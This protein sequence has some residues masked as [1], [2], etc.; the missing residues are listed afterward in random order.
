MLQAFFNIKILRVGI[1]PSGAANNGWDIVDLL[2][3]S[4]GVFHAKGCLGIT[5]FVQLYDGNRHIR[6]SR[7]PLGPKSPKSLE[8]VFPGLPA[9]RVE[10]VSKKSQ[11]TRKRV[12]KMSKSVFGD[13]FDTF[14]TLWAGGIWG[15]EGL[16]TP[17]YGSS[18][19]K[20]SCSSGAVQNY[21]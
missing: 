17:V 3:G 7:D 19:R 20:F 16:G 10:K 5:Y 1:L 2:Q 13:F 12:K 9:R 21:H 8:K 11:R 4:A 14:L 6:E 18:H 15:P